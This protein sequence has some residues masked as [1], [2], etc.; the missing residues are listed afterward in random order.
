MCDTS[1]LGF[2]LL[3]DSVPGSVCSMYRE[4]RALGTELLLK[5]FKQISFHKIYFVL[6]YFRATNLDFILC[7][8]NWRFGDGKCFFP[9]FCAEFQ[10]NLIFASCVRGERS[11][12][13][14]R[15]RWGERGGEARCAQDWI[16]TSLRMTY[17]FKT[18]KSPCF[19]LRP[20]CYLTPCDVEGATRGAAPSSAVYVMNERHISALHIWIVFA[21]KWNVLFVKKEIMP[22]LYQ[23]I[24][25]AA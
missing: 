21:F 7:G 19:D 12:D 1:L 14:N 15:R 20:F 9:V 22:L 11:R 18:N 25:A 24:S 4:Q 6:F 3:V 23:W 2:S 8:Q 13:A 10:V 5:R 17:I 16:L